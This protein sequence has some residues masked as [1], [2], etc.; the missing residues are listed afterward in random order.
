MDFRNIRKT[1]KTLCFRGLSLFF[2]IRLNYR[3][4]NVWI[5]ENGGNTGMP[6]EFV[7]NALQTVED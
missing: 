2:D 6:L 5:T 1:P 4:L 3:L 7:A